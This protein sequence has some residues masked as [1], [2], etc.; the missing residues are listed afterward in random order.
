MGNR[1][2][3]RIEQTGQAHPKLSFEAIRFPSTAQWKKGERIKD[4][5]AES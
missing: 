4:Q 2:Q 1:V 5:W 3:I